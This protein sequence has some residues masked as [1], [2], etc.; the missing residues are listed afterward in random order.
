MRSTCQKR[1]IDCEIAE[2]VLQLL[3]YELA[4]RQE[5]QPVEDL[6]AVAARAF[7]IRGR[8]PKA[9]GQSANAPA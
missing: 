2:A 3:V 5:V 6:N 4:A 9:R 1:I 7:R 8:S